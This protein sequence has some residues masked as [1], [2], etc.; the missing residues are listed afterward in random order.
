MKLDHQSAIRKPWLATIATHDMLTHQHLQTSLRKKEAA[1][2][3][4]PF[5]STT[6]RAISM[7]STSADSPA[8]MHQP[9]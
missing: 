9:K 2:Q 5:Y 6:P 8:L 7:L 4:L 1:P 3:L